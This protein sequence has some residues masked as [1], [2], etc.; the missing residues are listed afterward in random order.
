MHPYSQISRLIRMS[1]LSWLVTSWRLYLGRVSSRPCSYFEWASNPL[2][3][4]SSLYDAPLFVYVVFSKWFWSTPCAASFNLIVSCL[5]SLF[6]NGFEVCSYLHE[7]IELVV[8]MH[9]NS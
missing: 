5:V 2:V 8:K 9:M 4:I 6:V 3:C 1:S 7:K